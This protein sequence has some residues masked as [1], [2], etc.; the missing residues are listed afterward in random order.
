MVIK[1]T[2]NDV[3]IEIEENSNFIKIY[4]T[5]DNFI[6]FMDYEIDDLIGALCKTKE[7]MK[8]D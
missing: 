4:N 8:D 7:A 1:I 6:E 5:L 3:L 2:S